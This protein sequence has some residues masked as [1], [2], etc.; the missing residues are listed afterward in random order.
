[1][2][3]S[4][5]YEPTTPW[6]GE[7]FVPWPNLRFILPRVP[8]RTVLAMA[9]RRG[10]RCRFRRWSLVASGNPTQLMKSNRINI[11]RSPSLPARDFSRSSREALEAT[12]LKSDL[13]TLPL[14]LSRNVAASKDSYRNAERWG[15]AGF[16]EKVDK[17]DNWE[18]KASGFLISKCGYRGFLQKCSLKLP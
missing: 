2:P 5:I 16:G 8:R 13:R 11:Y 1:M 12:R 18:W 10:R 9:K 15:T 4:H 3:R 7:M 14:W 6:C 17:I